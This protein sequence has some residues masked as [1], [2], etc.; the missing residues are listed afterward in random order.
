MNPATV[1]S[2]TAMLARM[3]TVVTL[4]LIEDLGNQ[5]ISLEWLQFQ[6][7]ANF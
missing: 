6:P 5:I 1:T 3:R 4:R 7:C 2:S